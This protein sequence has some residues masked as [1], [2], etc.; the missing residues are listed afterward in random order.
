MCWPG[1]QHLFL[2]IDQI[3]GIEGGNLKTVSVSDGIGWARFY[4][5]PAKNAAVVI[6]VVNLCIAFG[7]ADPMLG[8]VLRRLDVDAIRWASGRTQE[9]RNTFLQAAFIALQNVNTAI[10]LLK[11]RALQ[12]TGTIRIVLN[13]SGL[14]HL[15]EGDAH[16]F[17]NRGNVL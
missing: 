1:G 5:V 8:G 15:L 9:A 16:A 6:D 12:W 10:P 14:E 7:A 3:R 17:G 11:F 4:A 13:D 2:A